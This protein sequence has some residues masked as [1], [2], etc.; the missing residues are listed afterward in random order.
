ML[1]AAFAQH[2]HAADPQG[3][4]F[5]DLSIEELANIQVTSV[6]KRP[7]RLLDAPASVFVITGEDIR[8]AGA[9]SL[10]DALRLAPNLHIGQLSGSGYS[11][12]AR[13]LN[14]SGNSAP[15]KLLV[16]IDGRSVYAP[17]FSGVFWDQQDVVLEDVERIEVI[18]GPGGTMW[19]V[20]AVNGVINI[21]TR[22]AH[23]TQGSL[24][25]VSN[26]TDGGGL[27]FRQGGRAGEASWRVY[28]KAFTLA[29]GETAA[30]GRVNDAW[31]QAQVGF[32]A[33]WERGDDVF[34][35]NGNAYRGELE[36]PEP[37]AI[38]V[39][40]TA[41]RLGDID[42]HGA[43]LTGRW[44]RVLADGGRLSV[45]AY[46]DHTRR[47]VPPTFTESL[48]IADLQFQHSLPA[49][50]AHSLVWGANYRHSWDQVT[51]SEI[52]AFLPP[53]DQ[54]TWASLFAQDEIALR[55][56]LSLTLGARIERNDYT[57]NELLPTARLSWRLTPRHAL[58]TALSRTVRAPTRLDVDAFIPGRPP[59]LLRG[60]QQVR[61][62]VAKVFELGYRGQPLAGLSYSA[63]IFHN[64]YDHLR[65]Q[66][67]DPTRTF[68]TFGSLMEG[69]A[70]GIEM[71]GS[72]QLSEAWRMSAGY[73][74]LRERLRLKPASN[75]AAGPGNAGKDPDH[76][77]QLRSHYSFDDQRDLEVGLR[78]VGA[79]ENPA[80]PS[81]WALDARF[82]WRLNRHLELSLVGRN[83]NGSHGEYGPMATR[84]ELGREV[85]VKL[86]WQ[87]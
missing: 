17:L 11:I 67:I 29:H 18:S 57:G 3:A 33:D 20:N 37:G 4:D 49:W 72:Y 87:H 54:Q 32:R 84:A 62:E 61:A 36:Q 52:I 35:L 65:T 12:S 51:N 27:A 85:G 66:E 77:L 14:G 63:T 47:Q 59:Y 8:R 40:G 38:S 22:S 44:E 31:N 81:Y 23:A 73:T 76:T 69:D 53:K 5:A 1:A 82:G 26:A 34:S 28:G 68:L 39:T 60:G 48:N 50:G 74:A 78:K 42:T 15:N 9:R 21:T 7:E 46:L 13:G 71:W 83:L 45:Q 16:M 6:S 41:L 75:D 10:P 58:W 30:G 70:T 2:A 43:N 25:V 80:V 56:D 86:V 24:A 64:E 79:L 55:P 19:G